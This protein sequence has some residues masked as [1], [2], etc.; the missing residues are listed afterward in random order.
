MITDEIGAS[1]PTTRSYSQQTIMSAADVVGLLGIVFISRALIK[2]FLRQGPH[3]LV[4]LI[5]YRGKRASSRYGII[6]RCAIAKS[7][8]P[9]S[10]RLFQTLN[11]AKSSQKNNPTLH[12][13]GDSDL[14]RERRHCLKV[15]FHVLPKHR[16]A[17]I[18]WVAPRGI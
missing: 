13:K 11:L 10:L 16:Q 18:G 9:R 6:Y 5:I 1:Y 8:R 17:Q 15:R 4:A 14:H 12:L 7:Y 3:D 2:N